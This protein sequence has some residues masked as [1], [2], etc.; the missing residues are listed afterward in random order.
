MYVGTIY[1]VILMIAVLFRQIKSQL[2]EEKEELK[3]QLAD[4][5]AQQQDRDKSIQQVSAE[6]TFYEIVHGLKVFTN[7][8]FTIS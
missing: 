3:S 6:V 7:E 2:E 8:P 1:D 4:I 5:K